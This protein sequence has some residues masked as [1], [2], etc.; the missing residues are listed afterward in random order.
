M[1]GDG[2][3]F[4]AANKR[5]REKAVA[6]AARIVEIAPSAE[7]LVGMLDEGKLDMMILALGIGRVEIGEVE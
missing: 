5:K 6:V 7:L 1:A 4:Y 2:S 3:K